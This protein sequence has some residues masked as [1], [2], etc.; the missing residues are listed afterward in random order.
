MKKLVLIFGAIAL[1]AAGCT[2]RYSTKELEQACINGTLNVFMFGAKGDGVTDDTEA[3]QRGIDFLA[4]RGGGR[5]FFPFTPNGYLLASPAREYAPNGRLV[6]AQL[7][8]PPDSSNILLEGEMPCIHLHAYQVRL[9]DSVKDHFSPTTFGMGNRNTLLHSTWDAPEVTDPEERPW[10]VIAAPEGDSC[11]GRFSRTIISMENLE[12]RVHLDTAKMY[13]TTSAAFLKNVSRVNIRNCQFCL[14]ENVGDTYLGKYLL[15]NP[16]HTVGLHTSGDQN[17]NQVLSNVAVQGFRYGFV[18]GEHV[19]ADYLYI[20]NCEEGIVFHDATHLSVI[21]HVVAQ[22]NRV[23]LATSRGCLFGNR[24]AQVNIIVNALNFEG[25]QTVPVPP[26][27]SKLVYGVYDPDNRLH[28]S[29]V[30]H[31]PWGAG[32]FPVEGASHFMIEKFPNGN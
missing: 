8:L 22:H 2:V 1:M 21:N 6:R 19:V 23:I 31:E 20:H 15:E 11:N 10:S 5:L 30:W 25:G 7:I 4:A 24:P 14:D 29:L 18:L 12:V 9:P 17:D 3:I 27:V 13:P 26:Y 32:V 28:G 16:C